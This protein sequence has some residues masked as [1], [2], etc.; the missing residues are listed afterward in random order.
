MTNKLVVVMVV[1]G[2]IGCRGR[3]PMLVHG[4]LDRGDCEFAYLADGESGL[5][6]VTVAEPQLPPELIG[7]WDTPDDAFDIT[8]V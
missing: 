2:I 5:R 6:A 8:R 4:F 3:G 1:M 7:T